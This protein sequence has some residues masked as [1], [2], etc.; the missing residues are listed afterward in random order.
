MYL[1]IKEMLQNKL[2]YS[3]ILTTIFLITFMV[4]FMTSLALG[5]V[6][7]NRAAID[8]WQA[9]GVVLSDYAND[10]LTASFIPEKDYQDKV[11]DDAA[12]LG[13]MFAVTNLV[14]SSEKVNVSVFGQKWDSFIS[15]E[16]VQGNYPEKDDEVVVDHSLENYGIKLGDA[17]QLN[18]S[19]TS[20]K[21]VGLTIGNKFFTEPV[22]FTSLTT[23]WTL[24]GT[25]NSNRSISSL[26]LKND[27]DVS[28]DNLKQ[29]TIQGMISKIPG[30]TPQE[31]VFL[32]MILA[33]MIITGL[34]V[35]IFIYII[36][37][38]KLGLYGIMRAQGI[39]IKTIVW[40]LFCQI[41]LLT[42]MG[43][44]LA[45]LAIG[46]VIL[47]LPGTFFFYTSWLAYSALS[48]V[49]CLMALFGGVISL[50]RLLKVDPITAIAE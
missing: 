50:P 48:I 15:P 3:L 10:N 42:G 9:S 19:D 22:V 32:G 41:F 21:I 39:Q 24:Q 12:P 49:I 1:A 47:V 45:L 7:N 13:Y 34:I 31:N 35:G 26:V 29:I 36:T 6:R 17:I 28:G 37:I 16:L 11:S 27:M 2:R 4:F 25:I 43:I 23:Y 8:N 20:Y 30:Y 40:S 46:G 44:G 38:Q 14:D 33:M 18:G 5:L